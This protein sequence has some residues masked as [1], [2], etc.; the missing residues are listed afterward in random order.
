MNDLIKFVTQKNITLAGQT[1]IALSY[2][3]RVSALVG[4]MKS[5][6][7]VK[8]MLKNKSE[9]LQKKWRYFWHR[10]SWADIRISKG[11]QTIERL[12]ASAVFKDAAS[13]NHQT[14]NI[15]GCKVLTKTTASKRAGT[16]TG[17]TSTMVNMQ[18][19]T[20]F[21]KE[22]PTL[23]PQEKLTYAHKLVKR[24]FS[25]GQLPNVQIVGRLKHF[26]KK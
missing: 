26:V 16:S 10:L 14:N 19:K 2:H 9:L 18:M 11:S 23:I 21:F 5:T 8:S 15:V 12:L 6:I 20:T 22:I 3:R 24:L 1:N 4:V 17:I 25:S 13:G 7:Q